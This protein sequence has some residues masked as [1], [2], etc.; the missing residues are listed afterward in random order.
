MTEETHTAPRRT[1]STRGALI[2]AALVAVGVGGGATVAQMT[3]PSVEMAPI[4]PVAIRSLSDT[5]SVVTVRGKI[6]E[7]YG[8]M[9]I[10]ADGTGRTL[11]EGGRQV[12]GTGLVAV[13]QTV[14]VQG[15]FGRSMLHASFLVGADGKVTALRPMPPRGGP[16][17]P[18]GPHGRGGPD[19]PGGPGGPDGPD[20]PGAQDAAPPPPPA[21]APN[22][23]PGATPAV[24]P[25]APAAA[26][27]TA[28]VTASK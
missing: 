8:P 13:G 11:V 15:R 1:I 17:G 10:L 18:R 26:R 22:A 9:F 3:A 21:A 5:G 23:T 24:A 14:S 2:A 19:G 20:G 4:K 12:D 16:G 25:A 27:T 28:T 7:T 6:A